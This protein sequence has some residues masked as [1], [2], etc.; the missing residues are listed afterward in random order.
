MNKHSLSFSLSAWCAGLIGLFFIVFGFV[1]Y[2]GLSRY[3]VQTVRQ[4]L[5]A[6]ANAIGKI[7][8]DADTKGEDYVVRKLKTDYLPEPEDRFVRV[9][10]GDGSILY[11]SSLAKYGGFDAHR[12]PLRQQRD[13]RS[14][15]SEVYLA[16][17]HRLLVEGIS[18][19]TR[20]GSSYLVE[21]GSLYLYIEGVLAGVLTTISIG[22]ALFMGVGMA[23]S[24][25]LTKRALRPVDRITKLA[26]HITSSS[27]SERLPVIRTGDELERLSLSLNKMISRLEGAFGHVN[28]FSADVSHELRTPLTILRGEL[29][30]MA[31]QPRV[32]SHLMDSISS[33]L[34]ETERLTRIVDHL[35]TLAR[36]DSDAVVNK[37]VIRSRRTGRHNNRANE[38]PGRGE[39]YRD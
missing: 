9:L 26:E 23:G 5:V 27:L 25:I 34:D 35:L 6:D 21:A 1:V 31:Q 36:L 18:V 10:R 2:I 15:S 8:Q 13:G 19:N 38:T 33:A 28:R 12:M 7:V 32:A 11:Q 29:E 20:S 22:V 37:A 24:W 4:S 3:L 30:G 17:H 14:Y 39:A 16:D